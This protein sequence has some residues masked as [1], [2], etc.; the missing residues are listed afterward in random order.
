MECVPA[1][2]AIRAGDRAVNHFS[3]ALGGGAET[4]RIHSFAAFV[5]GAVMAPDITKIDA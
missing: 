2:I 4:S 5:E 1:S 3:R